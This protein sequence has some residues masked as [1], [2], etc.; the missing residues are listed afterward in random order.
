MLLLAAY[1]EDPAG[2]NMAG[3]F[4]EGMELDGGI[5]RGESYDMAL[6]D[7]PAISA[8]WLESE[9]NYDG[10]VFLSK[11]A[12]QSGVLALT[13][14]T[15]GNFDEALYGGNPRQVAVPLPPLQ[16]RYFAELW[17]DRQKYERF[18]ITL[19]TTHHGPTA[20]TKPALF[21]E[22]GTTPDQWNDA[23]LCRSVAAILERALSGYAGDDAGPIAIGFGGTHYPKKFT[24]QILHGPYMFGT[25]IPKHAMRFLD[26]ELLRHVVERNREAT[27]AMLDWGSMGP[28]RS[29]IARLLEQTDLEVVRV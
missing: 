4:A 11:H 25:I 17:Q 26:E 23:R 28:G 13:C 21:V 3:Y 10:Y 12:A 2:S 5:Y 1:K 14:H 27:V 15:T 20:L 9:F 6:L 16:K 19:E 7:T 29:D 18:D 22:V 8:D 24:Y